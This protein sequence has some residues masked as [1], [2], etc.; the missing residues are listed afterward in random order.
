MALSC[1]P[2]LLLANEPMIALD[3]TIWAQILN[4]LQELQAELH[5]GYPSSRTICRLSNILSMK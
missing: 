5:L 3:V 4:L 1:R 2:G